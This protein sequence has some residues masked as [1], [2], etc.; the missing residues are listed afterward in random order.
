LGLLARGGLGDDC[1]GGLWQLK[2]V[3]SS[4]QCSAQSSV[5]SMRASTLVKPEDVNAHRGE[6][7]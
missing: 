4:F 6:V 2:G 3:G 7:G 5:A 1:F